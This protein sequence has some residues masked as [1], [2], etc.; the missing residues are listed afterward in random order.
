LCHVPPTKP[1]DLALNRWGTRD[2]THR[3]RVHIDGFFH[4]L[5]GGNASGDGKRRVQ[6]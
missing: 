1:Q 3:S 2:E 4:R 6:R 5:R